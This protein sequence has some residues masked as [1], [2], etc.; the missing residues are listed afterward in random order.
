MLAA[1]CLF[2]S[3][4][5]VLPPYTRLLLPLAVGAPEVSVWFILLSLVALALVLH[6]IRRERRAQLIAVMAI[7]AIGVSA[8]PLARFPSVSREADVALRTALGREYIRS[9]PIGLREK[10]KPDPLSVTSL[11]FG[12]GASAGA[13]RITRDVVFHRTGSTPLT[14]DLYQPADSGVHPVLV[15]IYGGAWQRG[16]PGDHAEFASYFASQGY[17][18]VA[19][20]YRHAPA[21]QFPVQVEDVRMALA[22]IGAN[23]ASIRADT[24]RMALIGRSAGAHLAMMAAYAVDA[25]FVRG[26]IDYYGPVDLIEGYEHPPRPDPLHVREIEEAFLGGSPSEMPDRYRAASPVSLVTRRQP[27]TLLIYGGRDH[28]VEPRFGTLLA[29]RLRT[30][31]TTVVHLEIPW[32][33][34]AFDAIPHGPSGQLSRYV[35]ER[36]L[37]WVMEHDARR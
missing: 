20:D 35:T 33:E 28:I 13:V 8:I 6:R 5:I 37:A 10:W 3:M 26:V 9:V 24:S 12:M 22:W 34:H 29:G 27:P 30:E 17:V 7:S 32:A 25:P 31:G 16:V 2:M 36:F 21:F 15:Q 4:W 1:A 18:V 19:I 14:L 23:A 11:L